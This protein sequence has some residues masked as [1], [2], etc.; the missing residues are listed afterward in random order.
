[1]RQIAPMTRHAWGGARTGAGRPARGP[2]A[3][4]RH[5]VR[6]RFTAGEARITARVV[7][8]VGSLRRGAARAAIAHAVKLTAARSNFRIVDVTVRAKRLELVITA[9]DQ[10]ALSRGMQGFQVSA[11]RALNRAAGRK[12]TVFPDRYRVVLGRRS[13]LTHVIG[14]AARAGRLVSKLIS[15]SSSSVDGRPRARPARGGAG[16][17][18]GPKARTFGQTV[19]LVVANPRRLWWI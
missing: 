16:R 12:G 2:V 17:G 6:T 10:V 7:D 11:A 4:E 8:G 1:M 5:K 19:R 15:P 13:R 14:G 9:D 18:P 3:S